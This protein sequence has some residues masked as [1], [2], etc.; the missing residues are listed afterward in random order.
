MRKDQ[1]RQDMA[2][3]AKVQEIRNIKN[4]F[5]ERTAQLFGEQDFLDPDLVGIALASRFERRQRLRRATDCPEGKGTTS[6]HRI[7]Q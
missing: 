3:L 4:A 1:R 6:T 2:A 7:N 5:G